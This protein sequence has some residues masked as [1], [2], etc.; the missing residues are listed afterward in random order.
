ME[1]EWYRKYGLV[2]VS[3]VGWYRMALHCIMGALP[4][5]TSLAQPGIASPGLSLPNLLRRVHVAPG[6]WASFGREGACTFIRR[7]A[8]SG[9]GGLGT[10]APLVGRRLCAKAARSWARNPAPPS[11]HTGPL[12]APASLCFVSSHHVLTGHPCSIQARPQISDHMDLSREDTDEEKTAAIGSVLAVGEQGEQGRG[13]VGR[14]RAG[15]GGHKWSRVWVAVATEAVHSWP[16]GRCGACRGWQA[17]LAVLHSLRFT[18]TLSTAGS[19][20]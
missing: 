10:R 9:E 11:F 20:S 15:R 12:P 3:Q 14:G 18:H 17:G 8:L 4:P 5:E 6:S 16:G 19:L 7:N 2:H 13:G 1:V